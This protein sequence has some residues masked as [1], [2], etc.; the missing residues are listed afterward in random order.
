MKVIH[1]GKRSRNP[2]S[3]DDR[4]LDKDKEGHCAQSR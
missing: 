2:L 3:E 4:P 1:H